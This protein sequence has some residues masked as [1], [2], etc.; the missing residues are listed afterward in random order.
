[1]GLNVA[2]NENGPA[3]SRRRSRWPW[4]FGAVLLALVSVVGLCQVAGWPFLVGPMQRWLSNSLE[5]RIG[6]GADANDRTGV[7]IGLVGSVRVEAA[8]LEIGAPSW[9]NAPH[10]VLARNA[11]IEL[12]YVDLWH[13]YRGQPLHIRAL[14]A[15]RLDAQLERLPDGRASW[16]FGAPKPEEPGHVASFPSFGELYVGDGRLGLRD[17][18]MATDLDARFSL[19]ERASG[20]APAGAASQSVS[21]KAPAPVAP[22][23]PSGLQFSAKG[24]YRKLPLRIELLTSSVLSLAGPNEAV[25][26]QP[27]TLDATVGRAKLQFQG[28]ASDPLHLTGL[29]GRFD[30]EGP[31]L[32]AVGDPVGVTLPTTG[33]FKTH[34]FL[35]KEDGLWK[36]VF[37]QATVGESRLAG[38]FTYDR[39]RPV[40]LLSGR[41]TGSRLLLKDLGPAL[42]TTPAG[43]PAAGSP[44]TAARN[45]VGKAGRVLPD[46]PFDLPALRAM[47]A[48][49][50]VDIAHV[51]L[52]TPLLEPLQPLRTHLRL[53]GGMLTLSDFDARTAQGRLG[54]DIGVDGRAAQALW[55]A[56]LRLSGVRLERWLHQTRKD[57]AA[58]P[59]ITGRLDGEVKV[60]GKGRST[61][62]ILGSLDGSMRFHLREGSLSHLAVEVAGIDVAQ[63]LGMIVV[64]D[65][66]LVVNCNVADLVVAKGVAR[67]RIFV[68]DTRNST[69]WVDGS[70]SLESEAFDLRAVVSP[71]DFS[72]LTLR[73]PIHVK[74]TFSNPSVSLEAGKLGGMVGAAALLSLLNPL[75]AVIPFIDPGSEDDAKREAAQCAALAERSNL[76][77][78][79]PAKALRK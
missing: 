62:E 60:S 31:S 32:A 78:V 20:A 29:R 27:V 59:Y 53:V 3:P 22:A 7:R 28:T 65:D 67:P 15:D 51:D 72:P 37:D 54:G 56:D 69:V 39:G 76:A 42:G 44:A 41:L 36:A 38:A 17:E 6:F 45:P 12:G 30:L 35:T 1:M 52:G 73:T 34:G 49:V 24:N 11:R 46:R 48:N 5:R 21:G 79:E 25:L 16:Q 33:P 75:L 47:D 64:G 14:R 55:T 71:K 66:S 19:T 50:L 13:A 4:V 58:P 43:A 23:T 61:A 70:L 26:V 68:I 9:S 57:A 2:K 63:A 74:G 8:T 10:M 40:P 77:R 18:V